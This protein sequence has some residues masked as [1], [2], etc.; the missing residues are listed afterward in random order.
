MYVMGIYCFFVKQA[1]L[2]R[3]NKDY[4]VGLQIVCPSGEI[5]PYLDSCTNPTDPLP[6][7]N[8]VHSVVRDLIRNENITKH[9]IVFLSIYLLTTN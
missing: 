3:K 7:S 4:L 6:V 1:T 2:R 5:C 9:G 8:M